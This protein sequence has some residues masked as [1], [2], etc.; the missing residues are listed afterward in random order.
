VTEAALALHDVT[1]SYGATCALDHVDLTVR[2]G[3]IVGLLG[4]NGAMGEPK[5]LS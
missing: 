4:P 3:P 1:K 5:A 2:A